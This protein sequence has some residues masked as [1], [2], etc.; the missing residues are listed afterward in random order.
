[1]T[2]ALLSLES[3]P[4]LA[5][6]LAAPALELSGIGKQFGSFVALE[7]VTLSVRAGEVHCLLGENGAGKSTLCNLVF[8]V[9]RPDTGSLRLRGSA[10][11]PKNPAHALAAGVAM[12]HQHFSL[13]GNMTGLENLLLLPHAKASSSPLA[14]ALRGLQQ[15]SAAR[16][17][18][19]RVAALS[20]Q[21]GLQATL[22]GPVEELTVGERQRLEIVKCLL[23]DPVLLVLDEPTAVLPPAEVQ[24]LLA[25]CR[26]IAAHGCGV[27]LVTHK[28]AEIAAVADRTSVIRR[29]KLRETVEM[30]EADLDQLVQTMV[31]R[32]LRPLAS[33]AARAQTTLSTEPLSTEPVLQVDEL[34]WRDAH[35]AEKL[36]VSFRV[37]PGEIVG[38]AGVEGNGQSELAALLSG[39]LEAHSGRVRMAGQDITGLS[40]R[41][42]THLGLGCVPEDRHAVGCHLELSVAENLFLG[43][44]AHFTRFGWLRRR[45]MIE[46]AQPLMAAFDVRGSATAP[47]AELSGGN[48]QKAVLARELSLSPLRLLL[49]AQPTRGLD[50]GAV[51]AV[52]GAFRAASQRGAAVLLISS[53]LDEVLAV[54]DR[55][56][57]LYRGRIVG[58]VGP[59]PE[60]QRN[61]G[62]LMSG[63]SL[64]EIPS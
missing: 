32:E 63:Q 39:M 8:G 52:Y 9:H 50:V 53:E 60:Q 6:G 20:A 13:V 24:S 62:R 33:H 3:S 16:E 38:I 64:R 21:F 12:V 1:M 7:D 44:L 43:Q 61:V 40:P 55:V 41:E 51:E 47:L 31:G 45:S 58:E 17:L 18:R 36:H 30:H 25:I 23:S 15:A 28:L 59:G 56:L 42:L 35:G 29:G 49:A 57:V 54:A 22:D 46:A 5:A 34:S 14:A 11:E 4:P 19:S 2:S 27:L 10:F 26:N 48:Q 37:A